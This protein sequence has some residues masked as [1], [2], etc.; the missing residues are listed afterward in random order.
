ML[1]TDNIR[2]LLRWNFSSTRDARDGSVRWKW[3]A[4]TRG[5]EPARESDRTFVS[6][7]ECIADARTHGFVD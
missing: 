4:Y 6:L 7:S 2:M 1:D 3:R 5:E